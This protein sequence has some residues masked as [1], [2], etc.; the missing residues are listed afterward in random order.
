MF[1]L[2]MLHIKYCC[3]GTSLEKKKL[4]LHSRIALF[5]NSQLYNLWFMRNANLPRILAC[6]SNE[7]ISDL[8]ADTGEQGV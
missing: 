8:R 3:I 6:K 1:A 5:E 2:Q 4:I 7:L